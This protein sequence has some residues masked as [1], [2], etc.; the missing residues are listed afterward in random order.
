MN[1]IAITLAGII[2]ILGAIFA[3]VR[4]H[5]NTEAVQEGYLVIPE[6]ELKF[7]L[8]ETIT[9]VRYHE[10]AGRESV[11]F[12]AKPVGTNV[13]FPSDVDDNF[14]QYSRIQ[15]YRTD[16]ESI[17]V[18][19]TPYDYITVGDYYYIIFTRTNYSGIFGDSEKNHAHEDA[20]LEGLNEM[21]KSV[22]SA[23]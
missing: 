1:I 18:R 15:L 9:D 13:N 17:A 10:V 14:V 5:R 4:L 21:L 8:P 6:W 7:E 23:K 19:N 11:V 2:L 12:I 16:D 22:Q 3:I 20:V